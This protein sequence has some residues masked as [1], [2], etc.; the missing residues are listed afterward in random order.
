MLRSSFFT[1]LAAGTMLVGAGVAALAAGQ[2][3]MPS[4]VK[5]TDTVVGKGAEAKPGQSVDVQYTGWIDQNGKKGAKF[6]SSRDRG[7]KPFTFTLGTGQVIAGWDEGVA[8]MKVGGRRTL[9]IPP[10]L[11]YGEK[12]SGS[13]P[14]GATLIF[15]I[16]LVGVH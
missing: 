11:A 3:V 6:D 5:Y 15:D 10:P 1:S 14:S 7:A 16:E 9:V 2:V 8:K 13:I 4:G 12:G